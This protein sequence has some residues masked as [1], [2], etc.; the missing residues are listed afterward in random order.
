MGASVTTLTP[1][2]FK[3]SHPEAYKAIVDSHYIDDYIDSADTIEEAMKLL[4]AV[5]FVHERGGFELRNVITNSA[6][7][8]ATLNKN[9]LA[10]CGK[11]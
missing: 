1:L 7:V 2:G 11:E 8:R 6:E 9:I 4:R 3:E 5:M 10:P